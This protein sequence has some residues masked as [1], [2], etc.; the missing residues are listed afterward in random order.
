VD[1]W[2]V[3]SEIGAGASVDQIAEKLG[4]TTFWTAKVTSRLIQHDLVEPV[5]TDQEEPV[6]DR[7]SWQEETR[8]T[9]A[10]EEIHEEST[11]ELVQADVE[12]SAP[13]QYASDEYEYEP[14]AETPADQPE[15]EDAFAEPAE[16]EEV[17][18]NESWWQEPA[19]D[20]DAAE[21]SAETP[22]V[23]AENLSEIPSTADAEE[24]EEDTEAFLEK[25]FSELETSEPEADEGHGLLRRRRMGSLRDFSSDS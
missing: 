14:A 23:V 11:E 19:E 20:E 13:E 25:V 15:T 7:Y 1:D 12:E 8:E 17:N 18:P 3:L 21:E 24:V 22:E 5:P 6:E 2:K 9:H 16:D 10:P 4:T